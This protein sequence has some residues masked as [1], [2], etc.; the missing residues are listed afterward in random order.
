M[1]VCENRFDFLPFEARLCCGLV[2]KTDN[3]NAYRRTFNNPRFVSPNLKQSLLFSYWIKDKTAS[4]AGNRISRN[5][6]NSFCDACLQSFPGPTKP[7]A[8]KVRPFWDSALV[9]LA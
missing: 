9:N 3:G 2:S 6:S 1:K 7:I 5:K 4:S 8:D